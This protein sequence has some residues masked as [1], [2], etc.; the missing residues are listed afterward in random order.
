MARARCAR[1][2]DHLSSHGSASAALQPSPTSSPD[3]PARSAHTAGSSFLGLAE[4]AWSQPDSRVS[5]ISLT[6]LEQGLKPVLAATTAPGCVLERKESKPALLASVAGSRATYHGR[7]SRLIQTHCG[8]GRTDPSRHFPRKGMVSGR[9]CPH[10]H[11]ECIGTA[12]RTSPPR[13]MR[14]SGKM[15]PTRRR[16]SGDLRPRIWN[17]ST[18]AS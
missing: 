2:F 9:R 8:G 16:E 12:T 13:S 18:S 7:I 5:F 3:R 10:R 14:G 17:S 4:R 1:M 15:H 11:G 6:A